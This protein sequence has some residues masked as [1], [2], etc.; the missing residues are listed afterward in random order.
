MGAVQ[1]DDDLLECLKEQARREG[2]AL[3]DLV[4]R[5]LRSCA[6]TMQRPSMQP[7]AY[8]EKTFRMGLSKVPLDKA[9]ALAAA[10]E[11]EETIKKT[12]VAVHLDRL[13]APLAD[14]L[15]PEVAAKVAAMQADET[16]QQ[17]VDYLADRAAEGRLD[18]AER[19]EYAA[20]LRAVDFIAVL[21]A[22]ARAR[23]CD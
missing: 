2:I 4:G 9:L 11:D 22:K 14:C 18:D 15:A 10:M 13:L 1:I 16:V 5:L 8:R 20:Y 12:T 19:D 7:T 17:R 23:L 21:Q 6:S 3:T